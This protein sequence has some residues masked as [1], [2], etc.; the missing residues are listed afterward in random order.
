M[1]PIILFRASLAEEEELN[2][3]KE[4]FPVITQRA[5]IQKDQLVIPRYSCLPYYKELEEDVKLLGGRLLNSYAQHMYVADMKNWYEDLKDFTPKTW[6]QL[7]HLKENTCS[8]VVK[9]QTNSKK[10]SW[11]THMFAKDKLTAIRTKLKLQEDSLFDSQDIYAREYVPLKN[12]GT[13]INDL[14]ISEEYRF[15][16]LNGK[17]LGSG[18]YWSEHV[19]QIGFIPHPEDVPSKFLEEVI[20][21][22]KDKIPFFVVDVARTEDDKW[23]VIELNDGQMSGLSMVDPTQL[24]SSLRKLLPI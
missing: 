16:V 7:S 10:H 9:G 1:E 5:A 17:I 21:R 19:D 15:F 22:V 24:Y 6:F 8:Y 3:C 13:A 12:F 4:H 11:N 14:P 20:T 23:I 18:F 2:V